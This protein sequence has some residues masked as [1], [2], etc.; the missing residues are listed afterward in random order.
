[1]T[2]CRRSCLWEID[3][4][5]LEGRRGGKGGGGVGAVG[6]WPRRTY[7]AGTMFFHPPP[8]VA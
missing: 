6:G 8:M 3:F 4:V 2:N 7:A 5:V 1:M